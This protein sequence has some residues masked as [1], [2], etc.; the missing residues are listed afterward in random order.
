M[1]MVVLQ[2]A[3]SS[4]HGLVVDFL[5]HVLRLQFVGMGSLNLKMNIAMIQ[6]QSQETDVQKFVRRKKDLSVIQRLK[7]V[8][9][10]VE[11]V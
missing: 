10:F 5:V 9:L 2:L 4:E 6:I 1:E 8:Q 11:M 3:K 7:L